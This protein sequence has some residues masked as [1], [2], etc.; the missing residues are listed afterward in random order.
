MTESYQDLQEKIE[1]LEFRIAH[2]RLEG[3]LTDE[4]G[5]FWSERAKRAEAEN[6]RLRRALAE[7]ANPENWTGLGGAMSGPQCTWLLT[8]DGETIAEAVL[9]KEDNADN[10]A[11]AA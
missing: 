6:D 10:T 2:L 8:C 5:E 4:H 7:Y 9:R 1:K 11:P 3:S